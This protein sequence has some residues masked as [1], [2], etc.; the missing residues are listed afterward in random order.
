M[1]SFSPISSAPVA[2]SSVS[3]G[4]GPN[5]VG[6]TTRPQMVG[7]LTATATANSV[8]ASVPAATDN[9]AIKEYKWRLNGSAEV[10]TGLTRTKS[11]TGLTALTS[12]N[13]ECLA[14][15]TSNNSALAPLTLDVS[16]LQGPGQGGG[17]YATHISEE[18]EFLSNLPQALLSGMHWY[19]F[20][21]VAPDR[22]SAPIAQGLGANSVSAGVALF[23]ITGQTAVASGTPVTLFLTNSNG[24]PDQLNLITWGG[25]VRAL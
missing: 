1:H 11:F 21:Q 9:V 2:G 20:A 4:S 17:P 24:D 16:T 7:P 22:F 8:L 10:S 23:D 15:D 13:I 25:T 18:F 3:G 19:V 6:D 12:Y 5:P 14:Y